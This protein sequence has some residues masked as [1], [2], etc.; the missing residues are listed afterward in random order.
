VL[1]LGEARALDPLGDLLC[2][3]HGRLIMAP[4]HSLM[5]D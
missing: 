2:S 5:V 3:G 4:R 1:Q